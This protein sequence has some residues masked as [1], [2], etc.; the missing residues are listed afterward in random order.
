MAEELAGLDPEDITYTRGPARRCKG[1]SRQTGLRCRRPARLHSDYCRYHGGNVKGK[2]LGMRSGQFKHGKYS[3]LLPKKL[4]ETY[5]RG[6]QDPRLLELRE[7]IALIDARL[8]EIT[9]R[10]GTGESDKTWF[11]LREVWKDFL[12]A[13]KQGN[14]TEQN[15]L[16]PYIN[17][18]VTQ[19][20]SDAAIWAEMSK[21]V[22]QR[23]RLSESEQK[24]QQ[25]AQQM[26]AVESVMILMSA[27]ITAL[28]ESVTLYADQETASRI[29]NHASESYSK[30]V[31][32]G[33]GDSR[34]IIDVQAE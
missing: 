29:L 5:E 25:V 2:T 20:A 15:I 27:T 8:A 26:I 14:A 33:I 21:L 28:K 10:L 13:I 7:E 23:R 19:G 6:L 3:K 16:L 22:E 9:E 11:D 30:L 17:K 32:P 12:T 4:S 34:R 18:L 31:G 1:K 24:R